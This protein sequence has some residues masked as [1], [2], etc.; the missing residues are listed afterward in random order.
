MRGRE[1]RERERERGERTFTLPLEP[2]NVSRNAI[3][4]LVH[5][6]VETIT[7]TRYGRDLESYDSSNQLQLG[8]NQLRQ[9]CTQLQQIGTLR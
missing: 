4:L 8:N 7:I 6:P 2:V 1:R 5:H 9:G 3:I